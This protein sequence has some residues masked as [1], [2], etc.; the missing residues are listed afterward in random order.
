M[1]VGAVLL[2]LPPNLNEDQ[3]H[4]LEIQRM[5]ILDCTDRNA[6]SRVLGYILRDLRR[7]YADVK[8]VIA[9]ADPARGHTGTIYKAAGFRSLGLSAP[10]GTTHGPERR[11]TP[12]ARTRKLKFERRLTP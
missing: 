6:E 2:A 1:I 12:R 9:Y 11:G 3:D 8:R 5:V 4:T 10:G 7:R